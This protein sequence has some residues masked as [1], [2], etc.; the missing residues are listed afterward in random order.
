MKIL[1]I[2]TQSE[3]GGAQRYVFDLA[4]RVSG[5]AVVA[6]SGSGELFT[7]LKEQ[8]IQCV[9]LHFLRR[10]IHPLWDILAFFEI[11]ILI[12]RVKPDVV[13]LN[14]TKAGILGG[15]V[16]AFLKCFRIKQ[17]PKMIYTVHG[18]VFLEPLPVWKQWL[19]ENLEW[20][21]SR[22]HDQIICVSESD[23]RA[24]QQY[25][26]VSE[27]KMHVIHNGIFHENLSFLPRQEARHG[28]LELIEKPHRAHP[29]LILGT[30]ANLYR[31]KGIDVLIS[32]AP[33]VLS[34]F[35]HA[36]FLVMGEGVERRALSHL[37]VKR[38]LQRSFFLTG[39]LP[40]ASRYIKGLDLFIMPSR[41]EGFPYALLEAKASG[42]PCVATAVGG[43][44]EMLFGYRPCMLIPHEDNKAMAHAIVTMLCTQHE[45]HSTVFAS[46]NH[47]LE[48]TDNVYRL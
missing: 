37:I 38:N 17:C 23:K 12:R 33:E 39:R 25:R 14:S 19:Y 16:H 28:L 43:V 9:S 41:K 48:A 2:I 47:M 34:E 18:W 13:H 3:W 44:V 24:A 30:I 8:N 29:S 4:T 42:V 45:N 11:F 40:N 21:T 35:P 5:E 6:S 46:G 36:V 26:I 31:T 1:Y 20:F 7:R 15:C 32:C 10:A 27:E 22:F